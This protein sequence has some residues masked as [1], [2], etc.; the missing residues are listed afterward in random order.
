[1]DIRIEIEKKNN[2]KQSSFII[3]AY[4]VHG[5]AISLTCSKGNRG[6][7]GG[8]KFSIFVFR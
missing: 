6:K 1:M 8:A 5:P 4:V 7:G 3:Y 2:S